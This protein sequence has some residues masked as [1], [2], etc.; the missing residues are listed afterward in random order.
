MPFILY[1]CIDSYR[2]R[3]DIVCYIK[4]KG[5]TIISES[6]SEIIQLVLLFVF[7]QVTQ[8][9]APKKSTNFGP[10]LNPGTLYL[11]KIILNTNNHLFTKSE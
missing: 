8:L 3:N 9:E 11:Y 10:Y 7:V 2:R 5:I 6:L 4:L 1:A